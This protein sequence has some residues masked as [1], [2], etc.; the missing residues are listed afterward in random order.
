MK[1]ST[2]GRYALRVMIDLAENTPGNG[3]ELIKLKDVAARQEISKDYMVHLITALKTAGLVRSVSGKHGGYALSMSPEKIG[4][5]DI[6]QAVIGEINIIDCLKDETLCH[7]VGDC[8]S[9]DVWKVVNENIKK[10]L[11][12]ITLDQITDGKCDIDM[13]LLGNMDGPETCERRE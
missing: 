13:I 8:K 9:R 3:S 1:I 10:T 7:R 5:L 12:V 4:V 6:V 2:R 11:A